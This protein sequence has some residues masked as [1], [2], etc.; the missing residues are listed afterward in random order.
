MEN[1][2]SFRG[3]EKKK[4]G[5]GGR[6]GLKFPD[7]KCLP[8]SPRRAVP[9]NWKREESKGCPP[10]RAPLPAA[11]PRQ[12]GL[13][14]HQRHPRGSPAS[15]RLPGAAPAGVSGSQAALPLFPPQ[16]TG[17]PPP[18]WEH[19]VFTGFENKLYISVAPKRSSIDLPA[20]LISAAAAAAPRGQR[21]PAGRAGV[22]GVAGIAEGKA[23]RISLGRRD[24]QTAP[25][26]RFSSPFFSRQ[27]ILRVPSPWNGPDPSSSGTFES[28]EKTESSF[29][30]VLPAGAFSKMFVYATHQ[31]D[32][33]RNIVPKEEYPVLLSIL[34]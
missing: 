26:Q 22:P 6:K 13:L 25:K 21:V 17:R 14:R 10:R 20:R 2:W 23:R 28:V 1:L 34:V 32:F 16:P 9:T 11:A 24:G 15:L 5:G 7:E 19:A 33:Q 27:D 29:Y 4:R 8:P 3:R 30:E 18:R 12:P 31:L